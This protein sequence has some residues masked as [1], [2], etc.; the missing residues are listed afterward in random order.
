[1]RRIKYWIAIM[2]CIALLVG[3]QATPEEEVVIGKDL[4]QM[5]TLASSA[6]PSGALPD[7]LAVPERYEAQVANAKG[8]FRMVADA[9][10]MLPE[11]D[12]LPIIRVEAQP[13]EQPVVDVLIDTLFDE[14]PL[15]DPIQLS[16][17]TQ[18]EISSEIAR[19]QVL[20]VALT[21]QSMSDFETASA[22]PA[23]DGPQASE[24]ALTIEAQSQSRVEA[25]DRMLSVLNGRLPAAPEEKKLINASGM[26][27]AI[28]ITA[29]LP[30][31]EQEQY[32]GM[33]M[34]RAS[35]GQLGSQG[36]MR[37]LYV[38]NDQAYNAYSVVFINRGDYDTS[39]GQYYGEAAW[40]ER[41][42]ELAN[43]QEQVALQETPELMLTPEMAQQTADEF[44]RQ[45]GVDGLVC[46]QCEKV[47]GGS[48][49]VGADGLRVGNLI[50]AYRLQYVREAAGVSLT[51]TNVETTSDMADGVIWN[52]AYE[53]MT[54]IVNDEGIVEFTWDAPYR[55]LETENN[56]AVLISFPQVQSVF[57]KMI[58][59]SNDPAVNTQLHIS[60]VRLG[61]MRVS[62]Q[63]NLSQGLLIPVWDFFG[64]L[65]TRY[66]EAGLQKTYTLEE[67]GLSWLT[68]NAID[69]SV[70]D[71]ARG[72]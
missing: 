22:A 43:A 51:Y 45:I 1:M 52:W 72:Y 64:T 46:A 40:Y 49:S 6:Y 3:C 33:R 56:N 42:D 12:R 18:S 8:S 38:S 30:E 41:A 31:E 69:G 66:E 48:I 25:I 5:L 32:K 39:V 70:V 71:R 27:Q 23:P 47:I 50:K 24:A 61:L 53:R 36:G 60:E 58:V 35:V 29:G 2:L 65:T 62:E 15:Y 9:N 21:G 4:E 7:R 54:I 57:E 63:N 34:D 11:V 26:L 16:E 44:L 10:I 28:D 20:R 55:L 68:I 17:M 13:F 67:E 14:G 37:A 59:V 19:L